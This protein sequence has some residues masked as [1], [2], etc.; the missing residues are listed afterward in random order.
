M[1]SM[2]EIERR[3]FLV[4]V[5]Y[6]APFLSTLPRDLNTDYTILLGSD[7]YVL[8]PQDAN[9]CSR[10]ELYRDGI[11]KHGYFAKPEPKKIEDFLIKDTFHEE[12]TFMNTLLLAR[13]FPDRSI[14]IHNLTVIESQGTKSK[15]YF[16]KDLNEF[17]QAVEDL[18]GISQVFT[19]IAV[20]GL[21]NLTDAWN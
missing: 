18:F 2:V 11:L 17:K 5:G 14:V 6:A 16:L 1:V 9:G 4:D 13:F 8:K 20:S 19:K 15:K 7:R 10:L 21:R 12:A 3:E